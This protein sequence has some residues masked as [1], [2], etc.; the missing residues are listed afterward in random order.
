MQLNDPKLSLAPAPPRI[1]AP[2]RIIAAIS[3]LAP[4]PPRIIAAISPR[5]PITH[6]MATISPHPPCN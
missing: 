1:L 3:P 6:T 5:A 2:P 4:A